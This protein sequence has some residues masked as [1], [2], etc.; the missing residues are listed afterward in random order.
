MAALAAA[1]LVAGC[2]PTEGAQPP[3]TAPTTSAPTTTD[4]T[5]SAA[6]ARTVS[7]AL[8]G[9]LLWHN[10]TW[11]S[12]QEDAHAKGQAGTD[13]YDFGPMF[14]SM[15]PVIKAADLAVCHE[16]VPVGPQGGPYS[17][18][19][20]FA[21][22]P[23]VAAGAA[24]AGYDLCT[25]GS[26]HSL[27]AGTA[28]ITRTV[29]DFRSAGIVTTGAYATEADSRTPAIYTT[30]S[31][32]KVAVVEAAYGL[33]GYQLP[34]ERQWAVDRIDTGTMI[35][36]ARAARAAGADIVLAA[37]HD[38]T[39]YT[40]APT[41]DQVANAK[42]LA[43]SGVIDLVYGH[44]A[45]TVQPWTKVGNTWVVYG[46]GN[47]IAQQKTEQ[48]ATYEGITARFTFHEAA[49]GRFEVTEATAIPTYVTHYAA[50]RPIR[51]VHVTAA[52][53]GSAPVPA[54]VERA[55]LERARDR[56]LA[57][58]RSLGVEGVTVG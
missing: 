41:A 55:T 10:T 13:Q 35:A 24:A 30:E 36:K 38:G 7:V 39:E 26:N 31:G 49:P 16:E 47:Q 21:A 9:D 37:L 8:A 28:G 56:T 6:P 53:D 1:V 19:P 4:P 25:L 57:A 5:P 2:G 22:P 14:G 15:G 58:V 44:H 17:N 51:L 20:S 43:E 52:L 48:S 29:A 34:A 33:N 27:D 3:A 12:A 45:H 50:G 42:A 23:Q 54:G 40:T 32:V 18:Y 46:L 11:F